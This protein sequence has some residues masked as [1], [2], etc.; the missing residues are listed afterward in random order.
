MISN[1]LTGDRHLFIGYSPSENEFII[2]CP[3]LTITAAIFCIL[4]PFWL[5]YKFAKHVANTRGIFSR[6]TA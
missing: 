1:P 3:S 4:G 5:I 2:A 6:K